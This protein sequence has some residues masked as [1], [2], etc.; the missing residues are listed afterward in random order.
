[1]E[2]ADMIIA[3]SKTPEEALAKML[4]AEKILDSA[5][6]KVEFKKKIELKYAFRISNIRSMYSSL[7][8]SKYNFNSIKYKCFKA[9]SNIILLTT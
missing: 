8:I 7:R 6:H 4:N 2:L 9:V 5:L 1:M 3:E